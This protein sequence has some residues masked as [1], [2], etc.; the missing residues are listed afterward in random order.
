MGCAAVLSGRRPEA[1][2]I[3]GGGSQNRML[4]RFTA[5]ALGVPVVCGPVEATAIGNLMVQAK[6]LGHVASFAEIREVVRASFDVEEVLPQDTAQWDDAYGRF[7]K[8]TGL[9]DAQ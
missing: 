8:L 3:V 6:A 5:N 9:K 7:L 1:L 4:N 2:H